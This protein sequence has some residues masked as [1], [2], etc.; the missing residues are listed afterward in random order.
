M[1]SLWIIHRP[2]RTVHP[3][4]SQKQASI[5]FAMSREA[6]NHQ[7]AVCEKSLAFYYFMVGF[8]AISCIENAGQGSAKWPITAPSI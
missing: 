7:A 3:L 8:Q 6:T 2:Y 5:E 1:E 4:N